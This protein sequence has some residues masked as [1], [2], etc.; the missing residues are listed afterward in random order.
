MGPVFWK[1][2]LTFDA[3]TLKSDL[4]QVSPS[5]WISHF[6]VSYHNG[7]WSG[8]ALRTHSGSGSKIYS[9]KAMNEY[10]DASLLDRCP[11]LCNAI[12]EFK[13]DLSSV[14]LLKLAPGLSIQ[15]HV[16]YQLGPE[17][18]SVRLH[19]PVVTNPGVEFYLDGKLLTLDEGEC[20][21]IDFSLPHRVNNLGDTDRI[22]LVLDCQVNDWIRSMIP[23][24][25]DPNEDN[26]QIASLQCPSRERIDRLR[27]IVLCSGALREELSSVED[28]NQFV[29]LVI[30]IA[31]EHQIRITTGDLK[32]AMESGRKVWTQ[33]WAVE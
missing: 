9:G 29:K 24:D 15:E 18:G 22:H 33:R 10:S 14:R 13:C 21:Y 31:E 2:P 17:Y 11:N 23:F 26:R 32:A 5:D 4:T 19:I 1:L 20:W 6:N 28:E 16:D 8:A 7:G 30:G 25:T 27:N 3:S 12:S